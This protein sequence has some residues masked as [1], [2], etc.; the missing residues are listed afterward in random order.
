MRTLACVRALGDEDGTDEACRMVRQAD[1]ESAALVASLRE[2]V[3]GLQEDKTNLQARL[4][5]VQKEGAQPDGA[6][7]FAGHLGDDDVGGSVLAE[8][9]AV[10]L[11]AG[12]G[13]GPGAAVARHMGTDYEVVWLPGGRAPAL[14][15]EP[16]AFRVVASEEWC[17][18]EVVVQDAAGA[19][20]R[21]ANP[22]VARAPNE[23]AA[24]ESSEKAAEAAAK[25]AGQCTRFLYEE[26]MHALD[27][28]LA[29]IPAHVEEQLQ[30]ARQPS[31]PWLPP[32]TRYSRY[33]GEYHVSCREAMRAVLSGARLWQREIAD[34]MGN[35]FRFWTTNR[36]DSR[37]KAFVATLQAQLVRTS[38]KAAALSQLG[39]ALLEVHGCALDHMRGV[40]A[41]LTTALPALA[42]RC[43][44]RT[45]GACLECGVRQAVVIA[46]THC[47]V[48]PP[49]GS[50]FLS[51]PPAIDQCCLVLCEEC[52]RRDVRRHG[53]TPRPCPCGSPDHRISGFLELVVPQRKRK[54]EEAAA[55]DSLE[56]R[57]EGAR[58]DMEALRRCLEEDLLPRSTRHLSEMHALKRTTA[59]YLRTGLY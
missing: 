1:R 31:E 47:D 57:L 4:L 24:E 44:L 58:D 36:Q 13:A 2:Q 25:A 12:P 34:R 37:L 55:E 53:T 5:S 20:H 19:E 9:R 22:R 16:R 28:S 51:G 23:Q 8:R 35:F 11:R 15:A 29:F 38:E 54:R 17:G 21:F 10:T 7:A 46:R 50:F 39:H 6:C 41:A 33:R 59:S 30:R 3:R 40:D 18:G 52:A 49:E 48:A 27:G 26:M 42:E 14:S 45:A 56:R 43:P 32:D